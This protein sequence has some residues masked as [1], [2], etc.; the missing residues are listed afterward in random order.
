MVDD[1]VSESDE[2]SVDT[3]KRLVVIG[4]ML[5]FSA[6]SVV[7]TARWAMSAAGWVAGL[8]WRA[9][10]GSCAM[11]LALVGLGLLIGV[12]WI[13]YRKRSNVSPVSQP[14]NNGRYLESGIDGLS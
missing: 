7:P 10:A 4:I 8:A 3:L 1:R 9:V 5:F 2:H 13:R 14:T 12:S 11:V 6:W